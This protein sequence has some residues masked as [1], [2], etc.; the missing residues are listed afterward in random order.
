MP[1]TNGALT[2]YYAVF[3][4]YIKSNKN[5]FEK[6]QDIIHDRLSQAEKM[7]AVGAK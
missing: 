1:Q 3:D 6:L 2:I 7:A 4:F 5:T